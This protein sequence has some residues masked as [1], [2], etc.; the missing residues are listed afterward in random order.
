MEQ[1]L[2]RRIEELEK[3]IQ[4]LE[5]KLLQSPEGV[6]EINRNK[7]VVTGAKNTGA[8]TASGYVPTLMNG[9]EYKVLVV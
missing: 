8:T 2:K 4:E 5:M 6:G 3:R 9:V 7:F 1:E